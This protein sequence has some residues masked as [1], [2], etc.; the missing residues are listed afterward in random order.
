MIGIL[1]RI[2]RTVL[3]AFDPEDAHSLA[4]RALKFAPRRHPGGGDSRLAVRAFGLNFPNPVGIAP[5]FD[6][7]G[8]VPDALFGVGFGFVEIGTVTPLP[9]QG[10]PRPRVFRLEPDQAVI[11][12]LGFNSDGLAV[13]LPRLVARAAAG[14]IVGVNVGAN[15]ESPDRTADYVRLIEQVAPVASYVT[16][17]ISSPNT[18]GL[19]ELQRASAV[20]DLLA[21]VVEV[22]D[23]IVP[24]GRPLPLLLKIAPD[25]SLPDLDDI[26]GVA[27]ARKIDGM[28][29]GNTTI[30]RPPALRD[31]V[32]AKQSGG[33][34]G[35]PLYPLATRMLAETYVRA[36]RAFPLIGVGGIDS[37]AAAL[38]KIR[39]GAD[40][41]QLYSALVYR[42]LGLVGEIKSELSAALDRGDAGKLSDLV[43]VDAAAITAEPRPA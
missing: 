30:G 11:N 32:T 8:E 23:R 7:R 13:V 12:R 40:L 31:Q 10:N 24:R 27:R 6:K 29:V 38:G 17:N 42:G 16:L 3:R 14:G 21:R 9:Q 15:K 19:R 33:L 36:E 5:G 28:I 25:L 34:S 22:R 26:V 39:A 43:G 41:V 35:R 2:A 20:D 4:V 37:G 1:D 18:P